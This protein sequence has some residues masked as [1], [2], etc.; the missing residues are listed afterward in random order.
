MH[1][2]MLLTPFTEV[3][4]T[5]GEVAYVSNGNGYLVYPLQ[6][7]WLHPFCMEAEM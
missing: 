2:W 3:V 6:K 1:L 7:A 5:A 4:L